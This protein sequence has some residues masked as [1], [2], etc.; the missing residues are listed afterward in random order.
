MGLGIVLVAMSQLGK[1][2]NSHV[3]DIAPRKIVL[4]QWRIISPK[5]STAPR[6]TIKAKPERIRLSPN[7]S[8]AAQKK[9]SRI[10]IAIQKYSKLNK[11]KFIIWH[12]TKNYQACKEARKHDRSYF[13]FYL[14]VL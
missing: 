5:L 6:H 14:N 11:I 7:S 4:Q 9:S 8:T 2:K 10:F 1:T 13:Q 12:P 3:L